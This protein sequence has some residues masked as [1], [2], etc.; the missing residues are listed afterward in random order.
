MRVLLIDCDWEEGVTLSPNPWLLKTSSFFK[1]QEHT[2]ELSK[3][4]FDYKSQDVIII[5]KEMNTDYLPP[6]N[7]LN[8]QK[9]RLCGEAL[10]TYP[11]YWQVSESI[12]KAR[13]DYYLYPD[14]HLTTQDYAVF[15]HG[16]RLITPQDF[17]RN[18]KSTEDTVEEKATTKEQSIIDDIDG[19]LPKEVNEFNMSSFLDDLQ[20]LINKYRKYV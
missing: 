2:V 11:N 13:P 5:F 16:G 19:Q 14:K 17:V 18:E 8:S 15:S 20:T 10:K 7:I 12:S 4:D 9:T 6:V 1:Q 3:G